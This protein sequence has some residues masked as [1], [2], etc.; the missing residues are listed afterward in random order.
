[1]SSCTLYLFFGIVM[2]VCATS[3]NT[4]SVQIINADAKVLVKVRVLIF[5][6]SGA[7]SILIDA[8]F[9]GQSESVARV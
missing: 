7:V 6:A 9:H 3:G 2:R 4:A 1:M 5:P 8:G